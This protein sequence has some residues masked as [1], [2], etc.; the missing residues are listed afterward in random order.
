MHQQI[1]DFVLPTSDTPSLPL[2]ETAM[3]QAVKAE[4]DRQTALA[5][6]G[7]ERA[8]SIAQRLIDAPPAGRANDCLAAL[9]VS[10]HNLADLRVAQGDP[11]AAAPLLCRVHE[12]LIALSL[13][14]A[15]PVSLRQAALHHSR[16]T[17]V[18]LIRHIAR[19]GP[20]PLITCA[21]AGADA[22]LHGA[23]PARH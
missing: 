18:A 23:S 13:D 9:V 8:L 16:E 5:L 15:R 6:A 17:Y 14:A 3:R 10:H 1:A 2:W 12:T 20:H 11:N 21:I 19:H 7:Y 22:A 4:R